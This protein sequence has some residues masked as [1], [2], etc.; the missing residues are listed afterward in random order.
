MLPHAQIDGNRAEFH[1]Y[2]VLHA[3]SLGVGLLSQELCQLP[4]DIL[5]DPFIT[6][7]LATVNAYRYGL[8]CYVVC[9]CEALCACQRVVEWCVARAYSG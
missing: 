9:L 6:H 4:R 5:D 8:L 1:A 3:A 2:G 7:A